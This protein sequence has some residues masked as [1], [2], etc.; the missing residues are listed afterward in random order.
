MGGGGCQPAERMGIQLVHTLGSRPRNSP[1]GPLEGAI[2][3]DPGLVGFPMSLW[4]GWF[5]QVAELRGT[6]P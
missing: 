6:G 4:A 1:V 2:Y 3:A 5:A